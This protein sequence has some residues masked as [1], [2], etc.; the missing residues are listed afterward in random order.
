MFIQEYAE[1]FHAK[2]IP[3]ILEMEQ[4]NLLR[5][6]IAYKFMQLKKRN[7]Q[8]KHCWWVHDI[9]RSQLQQGAYLLN[10]VKELHFQGKKFQQCFRLTRESKIPPNCS[11]NTCPIRHIL[12]SG[13]PNLQKSPCYTF[14]QSAGKKI[15]L[16]DS[17]D[18][19]NI[20]Y[21]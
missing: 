8:R 2:N 3:I 12:V 5:I 17:K 10:L 13:M 14:F 7:K 19:I 4:H 1:D 11:G 15:V 21:V 6:A 20:W 9:N 18:F 16:A